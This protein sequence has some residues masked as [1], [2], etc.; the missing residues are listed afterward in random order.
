LPAPQRNIT[1]P[2]NATASRGHVTGRA[3]SES[4]IALVGIL[5]RQFSIRSANRARAT[6]D[7]GAVQAQPRKVAL[8]QP[9]AAVVVLVARTLALDAHAVAPQLAPAAAVVEVGASG[10]AFLEGTGLAAAA[11]PLDRVRGVAPGHHALRGAQIRGVR[12]KPELLQRLALRQVHAAR[13]QARLVESG[14]LENAA[15]MHR[16]G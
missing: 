1:S 14:I 15:C 4:L 11:Q 3:E 13:G 2:T 16:G 7:L 8:L 6:Q 5:A 10:V 9:V 12:Q